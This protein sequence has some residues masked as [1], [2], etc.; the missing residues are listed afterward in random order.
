MIIGE[1]ALLT[2][3]LDRVCHIFLKANQRSDSIVKK[4]FDFFPDWQPVAP[5]PWRN[6]F[7]SKNVVLPSD[8]N[9][10]FFHLLLV[11]NRGISN[12]LIF[13][14]FFFFKST[15]KRMWWQWRARCCVAACAS[16]FVGPNKQGQQTAQKRLT[17][18]WKYLFIVVA[19]PPLLAMCV[20]NLFFPGAV[21]PV[22]RV[23][24]LPQKID[25]DA[26]QKR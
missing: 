5:H 8:C 12:R 10:L 19:P 25:V 18:I 11:N 4:T 2:F 7:P 17:A 13:L 20:W 16:L 15:Y 9:R 23:H 1:Q 21:W 14:F 6:P 22:S 24:R 26:Q 3:N